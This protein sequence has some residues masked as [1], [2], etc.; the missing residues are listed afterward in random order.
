MKNF[1]YE[2]IINTP[3]PT[4]TGRPRMSM[5]ERASQFSPFA[6]LTG[7]EDAVDETGRYT[8]TAVELDEDEKTRL[9]AKLRWIQENLA[10]SPQVELRYFQPDERKAGGEYLTLC[11]VVRKLDLYRRS[12]VMESEAEIF[13]DSIRSVDV[14]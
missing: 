8:D 3:Y 9:D 13:I 12:V 5:E 11:G 14:L 1:K 7:F 2:D 6:A 10:R 4:Q